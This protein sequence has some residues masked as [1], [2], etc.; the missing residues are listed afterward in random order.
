MT[1]SDPNFVDTW[2]FVEQLVDE[3]L[4]KPIGVSNSNPLQIKKILNKLLKA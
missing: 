4:V 3:G 1:P 2:M